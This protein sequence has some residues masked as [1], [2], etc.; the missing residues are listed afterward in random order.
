MEFYSAIKKKNVICRK[1]ELKII[2]LR[3][4]EGQMLRV[5]IHMRNLHIILYPINSYIHDAKV[6]SISGR[7]EPESY[8]GRTVNQGT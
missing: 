3:D 7:M 2:I 1:M 4:P 8:T 5:F 6:D